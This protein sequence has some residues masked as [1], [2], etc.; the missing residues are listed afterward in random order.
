M[1]LSLDK[2]NIGTNVELVLE[3]AHQLEQHLLLLD[4]SELGIF[5]QISV[6]LLGE[7]R[8]LLLLFL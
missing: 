5:E 6:L 8:G 2:C 1:V 7:G 3:L 4:E